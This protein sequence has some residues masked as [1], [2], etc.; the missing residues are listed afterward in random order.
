[1]DSVTGTPAIRRYTTEPASFI[2][3]VDC[4]EPNIRS[5]LSAVPAGRSTELLYE[6]QDLNIEWIVDGR[7]AFVRILIKRSPAR[8]GPP[9]FVITV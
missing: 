8:R 3:G 9:L 4:A 5:F 7:F 6:F 1:M 2:A